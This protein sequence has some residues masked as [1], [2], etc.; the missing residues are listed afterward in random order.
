MKKLLALLFV[1]I[2][3]ANA[4]TITGSSSSIGPLGWGK[5]EFKEEIVTDRPDFTESPNTVDSGHFQFELG[6]TFVEDTDLKV[7][8][9]TVPEMLTRIGLAD[10]LEARVVFVGFESSEVSGNKV[11]GVSDLGLGFKHNMYEQNGIIPDLSFITELY[12]PTSDASNDVR[13]LLKYLWGYDL[14][15]ISITGNFNFSAPEGE[16]GRYFEYSN[17]VAVGTSL[18]SKLGAYIEYFGIYPVD[19]VIEPAESYLNGGFTLLANS[20][21][22]F[23]LRAGFGLNEDAANFFTG[24]GLS[25]RR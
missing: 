1:F 8:E 13:P 25:F 12:L 5:K 11:E 6:Y 18:T 15:K 16:D 3:N 17:S 14:D 21:V 7:K 2:C 22:Q 9:Q 24:I 23:D 4:Q 19:D 20:D 10:D